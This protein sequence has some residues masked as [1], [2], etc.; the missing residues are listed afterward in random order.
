MEDRKV[1]SDK[2][3]T[4]LGTVW[5]YHHVRIS[6]VGIGERGVSVHAL[7]FLNRSRWLVRTANISDI[8]EVAML[9]K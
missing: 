6:H 9:G 7:C 8:R 1:I 2:K 5:G 4:V 3:G